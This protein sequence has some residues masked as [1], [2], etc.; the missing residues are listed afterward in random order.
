MTEATTTLTCAEMQG[1]NKANLQTAVQYAIQHHKAGRME[2]AS[3]IYLSILDSFPDHFETLYLLAMAAQHEDDHARAIQLLGRADRSRP[4]QAQVHLQLGISFNQLGERGK[5][6]SSYQKALS[7]DG[8]CVEAYCNL[9]NLFKRMGNAAGALESYG[10]A[11][12]LDPSIAQ[13]PYN[14]GVLYQE[15]LEP[16]KAIE[17]FRKAISLKSDYAS[18]YNHL[19]V[20]LSAIG[21]PEEAIEHYRK[22]QKLDPNSADAFYNLHALLLDSTDMPEA[23]RCM[24]K[25]LALQPGNDVYRLSMGVLHEYMGDSARARACFAGADNSGSM[26]ADLEAWNHIKSLGDALPIVTGSAARIFRLALDGAQVGG[27]VLEFGVYMGNSIRQIAALVNGAVH[28]F[29]SFEGI[30][31]DW[32]HEQKG[33]YS[34]GGVIP[35]VPANVH[36]HAGWFEDTVPAFIRDEAGPI[37]FINI[38]CD[39]YSSTRTILE[40]LCRQI[41]PGTV[42]VFDEYIG[43]SGWKDHEFKAFNEAAEKYG[44]HHEMLAFSFVTKQVAFRITGCPDSLAIPTT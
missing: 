6:V 31:E 42:I 33:S 23:V 20:A 8:A 43:Y 5:A 11:L 10:H 44:W 17:W 40:L 22:A 35:K 28:G 3:A 27:L 41:V 9:G 19:G 25:A 26:V 15:R 16:D 29:D 37:R 14:L 13:I 12:R 39:L 1:I 2:L 21:H 32:C 36:L 18:A 38:D 4:G 30:P 24:E 34:T 7:F